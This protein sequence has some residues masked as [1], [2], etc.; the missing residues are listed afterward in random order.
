MTGNGG[1]GG[2]GDSTTAAAAVN[3]SGDGGRGSRRRRRQYTVAAMDGGGCSRWRSM[4]AAT[5]A[6]RQAAGAVDDSSQ[7]W[8]ATAAR[9]GEWQ[10]AA[11]DGGGSK[12]TVIA[13]DDND[14]QRIVIK[15]T[16]CGKASFLCT[17]PQL[18]NSKKTS[19]RS[20]PPTH[21][22]IQGQRLYCNYLSVGTVQVW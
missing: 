11:V 21:I 18:L 3:G 15:Q 1:G 19:G 5:A 8:L 17:P 9:W 12:D 13:D 16:L 2:D 22:C 4:A 6:G 7:G 14:S 10:P 20:P